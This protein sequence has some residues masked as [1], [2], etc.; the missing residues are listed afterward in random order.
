M[1][2][3]SA[4]AALLCA[5]A[6]LPAPALAQYGWSDDEVTSSSGGGELQ[7]APAY[8]DGYAGDVEAQDADGDRGSARPSGAPERQRL[9]IDPYIEANQIVTQRIN[10]DSET[11]V[12]GGVAAGVDASVQGRRAGGSVS[13]RYDRVISYGDDLSG[14]VSGGDSVTGVARGYVAAAPGITLEA[15]GLAAR[16]RVEGGDLTASDTLTIAVTALGTLEGREPVRRSGAHAGDV[17]A[18]AG[19][20]GPAARGLGAAQ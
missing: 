20:V 2:R 1:N 8:P 5:G 19:E 4:M 6:T 13:L 18:V 7:P 12:Y 14:D 10:P 17:V 9:R 16:S 3:I 15:G 11:A